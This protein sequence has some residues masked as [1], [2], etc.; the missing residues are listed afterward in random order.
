MLGTRVWRLFLLPVGVGESAADEEH[1]ESVGV[2]VAEAS[3]D[4][5]V[6]FDRVC[7]TGR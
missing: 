7:C 5:A 4:A 2:A 6:E 3:G 1:A